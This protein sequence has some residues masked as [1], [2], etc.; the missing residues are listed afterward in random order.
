MYDMNLPAAGDDP[1]APALSW[2][3]VDAAAM[4]A[5]HATIGND[6]A[7]AR[8]LGLSQATVSIYRRRHGVAPSPQ[9]EDRRVRE[10]RPRARLSRR[11]IG[12]LYGGRCYEDVVLRKRPDNVVRGVDW[13]L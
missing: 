12:R 5:W 3:P 6:A 2:P 4:R 10:K 7:I 13:T 1:D 8:H 9:K 11:A